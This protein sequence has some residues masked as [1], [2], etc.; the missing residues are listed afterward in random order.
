MPTKI[1][2]RL[3]A[4]TAIS[5]LLTG[6]AMGAEARPYDIA[7]QDAAT[8]LQTYAIQS[9]RQVLFPYEA[10]KGKKAPEIRGDYPDE[11]VLALLAASA[12]LQVT[13]DDGKTVTLRPQLAQ[14]AQG[15]GAAEVEALI[16]TAQKKEEAIQDVPI[17][18]SAFTAQ[19]LEEQKI[20]GGFDLLKAIPNVTFSKNNFT[21]YNFSIRGIGRCAD[22]E[23]PVRAGILRRRAG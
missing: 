4:G 13:A 12:G 22:S 2:T 18:I 11:E 5:A 8:A 21:S 23:P 7:A 9:G 17:A 6:A 10:A 15:G 20:E 16:V 19:A 3:L 1:M 14:G